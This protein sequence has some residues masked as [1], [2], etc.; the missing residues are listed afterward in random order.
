MGI[1]NITAVI[2][3]EATDSAGRVLEKARETAEEIMEQTEKTVLEL[4][5]SSFQKGERDAAALKERKLSIAELDGRKLRLG[6]RHRAIAKCFGAAMESLENMDE[7][8]YI[9]FLGKKISQAAGNGGGVVL[10]NE[11]DQ[12]TVGSRA[13]DLANALL[14]DRQV[15]LG[16]ETIS[17][18]GGFILRAGN[19][20]INSTLEAMLESMKEDV[21]PQVAAA[22]FPQPEESE[23][24]SF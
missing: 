13:V 1:E 19:L 4:T 12:K 22:L 2:L 15:S 10:F 17:A 11:K 7:A 3:G 9:D 18:R 5:E 14:D 23:R 24:R 6:A 8:D 21:I 20:E 16:A